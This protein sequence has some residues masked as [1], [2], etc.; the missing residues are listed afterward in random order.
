LLGAKDMD[1]SLEDEHQ[2]LVRTNADLERDHR[3]LHDRPNDLEAHATHRDKLR[4][5]IADLHAHLQRLR[6]RDR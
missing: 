2:R 6:D 3:E 1:D 4:Q 5:H